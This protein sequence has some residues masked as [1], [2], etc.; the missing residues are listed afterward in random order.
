MKKPGDGSQSGPC[1][2]SCLE[3]LGL[4]PVS[5]SRPPRRRPAE[6]AV[7]SRRAERPLMVRGCTLLSV[8]GLRDG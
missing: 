3:V 2:L 4:R 8:P 1:R 6:L 5:G 7:L